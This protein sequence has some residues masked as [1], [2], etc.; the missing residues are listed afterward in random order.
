MDSIADAAAVSF[1]VFDT[2]FVRPL[3]DPEDA[4]D[5]LGAKFGIPDFRALRRQ[6][7]QRAFARMHQEGGREIT[8]A[9]IYAGFDELPVP[10]AIMQQAEYDLELAL[11]LPNPEIINLF[12]SLVAQQRSVVLTSDM[13]MPVAFF[14]DLLRRHGLPEV[15]MFISSDRNATK[16]DHGELFAIVARDLG[17]PPSRILHI[18]DNPVSDVLR[19][20]EAGFSIFHYVSSRF[21]R[22]LPRSTPSASLASAVA[23]IHEK[24]IV[25]GTFY[26]LG[27]HYGGPAAVGFL[28][29][30][31]QRAL[32]DGIDLLLFVSRDGYILHR[33]AEQED[34]ALLPRH[35][36]FKGSRTAFILSNMNEGNFDTS[37]DFLVSGAYGLSPS[38][39][40]DRIGVAPPADWVLSDLGFKPDSVVSDA[41]VKSVRDLIAATRSEI[42]KVCRRNRRGLFQY[43]H[44]L[45]IRSGMH[46]GLV[47]IGWNGTTQEAFEL[48]VKGMLNIDVTGYYFCLTDMPDCLRRQATMNMQ[49]MITSKTLSRQVVDDIYLN[50]TMAELFFSAPHDAVIGYDAD[51]AGHITFVEDRGRGDV[52]DTRQASEDMVAG[53]QE[54]AGRFRE[55]CRAADFVPWPLDTV[56]PFLDLVT[57]RDRDLHLINDIQNFDC[58]G[59]TRNRVMRVRD[60]LP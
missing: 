2:L 18:G 1:D 34:P 50:R 11:T 58:W 24:D 57:A 4:F 8:L 60:Y 21:Y 48:T 13:Y 17:L 14:Q 9:G 16:R 51:A 56:T 33:L 49:A 44:S 27:F 52:T 35:V 15:P 3:Q 26:E 55:I 10:A 40:F 29:W 36:Y 22:P 53:A 31:E 6:A 19:A 54:F 37:I 7:Q 28:H 41:N 38:E 39:L 45:E 47:D 20:R 5:M 46:L 42:L 25:G 12:S 43:L 23:K 59:S 32:A 30:I